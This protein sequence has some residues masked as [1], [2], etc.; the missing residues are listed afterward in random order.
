MWAWWVG[1]LVGKYGKW[2]DGEGLGGGVGG[3][4]GG[5]RRGALAFKPSARKSILHRRDSLRCR[6]SDDEARGGY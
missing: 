2:E 5:K 6:S 3:T 4:N 1:G